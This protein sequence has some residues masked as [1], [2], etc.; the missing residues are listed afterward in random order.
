ML[1]VTGSSK[2]PPQMHAVGQH[3]TLTAPSAEF[4]HVTC[5]TEKE[6]SKYHEELEAQKAKVAKMRADGADEYDIKKQVREGWEE[7]VGSRRVLME[8]LGGGWDREK[9]PAAWRAASTEKAP[10]RKG[11]GN[12]GSA[13]WRMLLHGMAPIHQLMLPCYVTALF[14]SCR[15]RFRVNPR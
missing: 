15:W 4:N 5:R 3:L 2:R 1:T 6:L 7:G 12:V 13:E 9:Q 8:A 14:S 11:D 10:L